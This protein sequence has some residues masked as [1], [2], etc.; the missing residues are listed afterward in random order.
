ML[1]PSYHPS[2]CPIIYWSQPQLALQYCGVS[3]CF[4]YFCYFSTVLLCSLKYPDSIVNFVLLLISRYIYIHVIKNSKVL[5]TFR[6][7]AYEKRLSKCINK[8]AFA[9]LWPN[10][11]E[12]GING[13][14]FLS[15]Q[16]IIFSIFLAVARHCFLFS[17]S[18]IQPIGIFRKMRVFSPYVN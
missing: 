12:N 1:S 3:N 9:K 6:F 13:S 16:Y 10:L 7:M 4:Y 2:I 15:N 11:S 14:L 8:K 5:Y 17:N 18:F